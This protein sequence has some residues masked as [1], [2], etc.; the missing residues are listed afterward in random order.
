MEFLFQEAIGFD[1]IKSR[2]CDKIIRRKLRMESKVVGQDRMKEGEVRYG[3]VPVQ[4]IRFL[5]CR[6]FR[7]SLFGVIAQKG[8]MLRDPR[9]VYKNRKF[10]CINIC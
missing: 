4:G 1:C 7:V 6:Y 9:F 3:L 8:D 5:H 10:I 2:V